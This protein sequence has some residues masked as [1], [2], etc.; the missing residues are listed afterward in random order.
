[1][2]QA[3]KKLNSTSFPAAFTASGIHLILGR[4]APGVNLLVYFSGCV[5]LPRLRQRSADA[6]CANWGLQWHQKF[7]ESQ[8]CV[9][10]FQ[11]SGVS[12]HWNCEMG[13]DCGGG[14][15]GNLILLFNPVISL[16]A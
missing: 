2:R 16:T 9:C 12:V 5:L 15:G 1:M 7:E 4:S 11:A 14:R 6:S 3:L 10:V 8:C 13:L